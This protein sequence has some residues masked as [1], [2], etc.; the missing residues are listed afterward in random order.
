MTPSATGAEGAPKPKKSNTK[1]VIPQGEL[2]LAILGLK[3]ADSWDGSPLPGLLWC[4]KAQLRAAV[5]A[6]RTSIG[7]ADEADDDLGPAA[8]RLAELDLLIESSLKFVRNYLVEAHGSKKAAKGYYDAFGLTPDGKLPA[9]RPT[10]AE[11]LQKMV[12]ALKKSDYDQSK[13][14]TK[15]WADIVKEYAPLATT[16]SDVRS[17]SAKETGTKNTQEEPLRKMLRALRQHIKT[18]FP[19]TYQAEWRG[20]GYLKE[21][22]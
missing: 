16:S 18:N 11:K 7:L 19:E 1:D 21:S 4:S 5:L 6:F 14:G 8:R 17:E 15:Y 20:F 3:A 12:K 2:E 13:Y 10:R 9:A 22:Y